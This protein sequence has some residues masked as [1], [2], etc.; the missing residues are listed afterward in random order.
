MTVNS[1]PSGSRNQCTLSWS[2]NSN[3]YAANICSLTE[4][5]DNLY[6]R[7]QF[8][9]GNKCKWEEWLKDMCNEQGVVDLDNPKIFAKFAQKERM[10][11]LTSMQRVKKSSSFDKKSK[12][13]LQ[14]ILSAQKSLHKVTKKHN[15]SRKRIAHETAET[16]SCPELPE[17]SKNATLDSQI[18][19]EACPTEISGLGKGTDLLWQRDYYE[20]YD[21][22][23]EKESINAFIE[24][25][26]WGLS[27]ML[28]NHMHPSSYFGMQ[29]SASSRNLIKSWMDKFFAHR[30]QAEVLYDKAK[31]KSKQR[32][33]P[34]TPRWVISKVNSLCFL[35]YLLFNPK[36]FFNCLSLSHFEP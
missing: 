21:L 25:Y 2:I 33:K 22:S 17:P 7:D 12:D 15:R 19:I 34:P 16:D 23:D 36:M 24:H 9:K 6:D 32:K 1:G 14:R 10:F 11:D 26:S 31:P 3:A 35:F 27:K 30:F 29:N 18:H 13:D 28:T 4:L 8:E 5:T 20:S